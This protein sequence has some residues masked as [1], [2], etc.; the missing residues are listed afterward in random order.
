MRFRTRNAD[1]LLLWSGR[2][3]KGGGGGDSL[4][5]GVRGGLLEL[6]YNLGSGEVV[7]QYNATHVNDGLWHRVKAIR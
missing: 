3:A 7:L 5:L 2:R 1:G 6:R 4:A